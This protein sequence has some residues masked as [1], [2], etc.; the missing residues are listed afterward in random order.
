MSITVAPG[1]AQA[2]QTA[3]QQA[4]NGATL[5]LS[6]QYKLTTDMSGPKGTGYAAGVVIDR[7]LTLDGGKLISDGSDNVV[8][9]TDSGD[10]T[11]TGGIWVTGGHADKNGGGIYNAGNVTLNDGY[12]WG[13]EAEDNGGGVYNLKDAIFTL[14]GGE[15]GSHKS[16]DGNDATDGAGIYNNGKVNLNGGTINGNRQ[17]TEGG[18]IYNSSTGMVTLNGGTITLNQAGYKGGGI[19][20]DGG[21]VNLKSG[22]ITGNIASYQG[23]GIYNTNQGT[24]LN[25]T[26]IPVSKSDL[27]FGNG[28]PVD[29]DNWQG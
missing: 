18:G 23:G 9:V 1:N 17:P 16:G 7:A 15:V 2:L 29:H 27:V 11:L 28:S 14:N 22:E 19:Y 8:D 24:V 21:K 25:S 20:N 26:G 6:G 13:N 5:H 4:P 12:I 3:I 10:L